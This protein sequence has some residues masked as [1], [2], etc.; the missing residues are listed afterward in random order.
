M[1]QLYA[2]LVVFIYV[3]CDYFGN[4]LQ[5]LEDI[6][7]VLYSGTPEDALFFL[8]YFYQY[9]PSDPVAMYYLYIVELSVGIKQDLFMTSMT[10]S[11]I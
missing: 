9:Y 5:T 8:V 6:F 4:A 10:N 7:F 11:L 3:A 1:L 2:L